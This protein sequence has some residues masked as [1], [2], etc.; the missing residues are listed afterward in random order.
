MRTT[1]AELRILIREVV[2]DRKKKA[3][4]K[5]VTFLQKHKSALSLDDL[6]QLHHAMNQG[7]WSDAD[8]PDLLKAIAVWK[9]DHTA[10]MGYLYSAS[11]QGNRIEKKILGGGGGGV[12]NDLKRLLGEARRPEKVTTLSGKEVPYGSQK[13]LNDLLATLRHLEHLRTTQSRG[14]AARTDMS[15]AISRVRGQIRSVERAIERAQLQGD[16]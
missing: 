3:A 2:D 16:T 1:I 5:V 4:R 15:R 9:S 14:S 11:K 13:H 8:L 6:T 10:A 12:V 7:G